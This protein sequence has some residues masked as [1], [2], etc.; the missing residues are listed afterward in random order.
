M[1]LIDL[2]KEFHSQTVEKAYPVNARLLGYWFIGEFNEAFWQEELSYSESELSRLTGIP[3]ASIHRAVKYLC[4][5]GHLKT[6][7]KQ[8]T[9]KTIFKLLSDKLPSK[10]E[11][12]TNELPTKQQRSNSEVAAKQPALIP[13]GRVREDVKTL[14]IK[15]ELT[16][17]ASACANGQELDN[18]LEYWEQSRFGR[19]DAT[20]ISKLEVCLKRYGFTEVKAAMDAAKSANKSPYGVSFNFFAAIL[21]RRQ[22]TKSALKGGESGAKISDEFNYKPAQFG[23][24][25][26]LW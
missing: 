10:Q 13:I 5:R 4:D 6:W 22:S 7:R 8:K 12:S 14:D 9:G 25:D 15:T 2:F 11:R 3:Q 16:A 17:T 18:V 26:K 1:S 19:L 20:L 24:V 21:E 23:D